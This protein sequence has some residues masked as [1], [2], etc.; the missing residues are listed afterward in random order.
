MTSAQTERLMLVCGLSKKKWRAETKSQSSS[1]GLQEVGFYCVVS[2]DAWEAF[3]V[4]Q[5]RKAGYFY[6]DCYKVK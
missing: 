3:A 6:F 2:P 1:G 4:E 5:N